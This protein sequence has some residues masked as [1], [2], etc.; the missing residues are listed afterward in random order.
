MLDIQKLQ[1]GEKIG[2]GEFGGDLGA[3]GF[4]FFKCYDC[5]CCVDSLLLTLN[6]SCL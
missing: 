4:V 1:L 3:F 6:R 5:Y 2:D